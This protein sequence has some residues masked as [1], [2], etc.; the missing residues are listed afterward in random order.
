M[1]STKTKLKS[2]F[3]SQYLGYVPLTQSKFDSYI[4]NST[5]SQQL[6]VFEEPIEDIKPNRW[7]TLEE[8]KKWCDLIDVLGISIGK[9][10]WCASE[11]EKYH[12]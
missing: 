10:D 11:W 2:L 12:C 6:T 3:D 5:Q 1:Y 8:Q 7:I 9:L 4:E